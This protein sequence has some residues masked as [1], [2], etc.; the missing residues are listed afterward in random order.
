MLKKR[1]NKINNKLQHYL[2]NL[3]NFHSYKPLIIFFDKMLAGSDSIYTNVN[4]FVV[5]NFRCKI[6]NFIIALLSKI[7][8]GIRVSLSHCVFTRMCE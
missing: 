8:F 3:P 7:Q 6:Q 1:V 5:K 2:Y 4:I